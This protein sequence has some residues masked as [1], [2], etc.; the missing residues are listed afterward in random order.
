MYSF[1][2]KEHEQAKLHEAKDTPNI[3]VLDK[4]IPPEK[5]A[6]PKRVIIV[7]V[8]FLISILFGLVFVTL[9]DRFKRFKIEDPEGHSKLI[10]IFKK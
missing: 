4:A 10:A 5:K 1:I 9:L 7:V 6:S 8:T 3:Q 2:V